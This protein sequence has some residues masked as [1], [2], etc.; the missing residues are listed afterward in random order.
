MKTFS[1]ILTIL[2]L[3]NCIMSCKQSKNPLLEE[4]DTPYNTPPFDKI[5]A[6]H[7]KPA[8]IEAIKIH[9]EEIEKII[10]DK[11]DPTFENCIVRLDNSGEKLYEITLILS[12]LIE[13]NYNDTL[14]QISQEMFP[15][16]S[17]H[18]DEILLNDKLFQKIKFLHDN[19]NDLE[20]NDEQKRTLELYYRDFVRAGALLNDADKEKLKEI[21]QRLSVLTLNFGFNVQ[22]DNNNNILVIDNKD[23]LKGMPESLI[24]TGEKIAKERNMTGKWVYTTDKAVMIPFLQYCPNRELRK[25]LYD[26][27]LMRGDNDNENDNK[28]LIKEILDLRIQK[29]N[30]LGYDTYAD[31][32]LED[33][34]AKNPNN[35]FNLL[36]QI[37]IPSIAKAK[38]ERDEMQKIINNEGDTFKLKYYDWWYY[39]EKIRNQKY[40]LDEENLKP[41]F[42]LNAVRD[43]VFTLSNKLY[44]ISFKK[45]DNISVYHPDVEVY[46]VSKEDGSHLAIL[47]IDYYTRDNKQ[48]GAWATSFRDQYR[49]N[50]KNNTPLVSIVFNFPQPVG[51]NPSLLSMDEVETFFHE[52]GHALH[53]F[54][55]DVTY[56]RLSGYV[57][58]DFV[59]LPS[60]ILEHWA[61]EPQML[62]IYAK[63]YKTN[64]IIPDSLIEKI[65]N[66][67][68]FNQGFA[69]TEFLA[70]SYLDMDYHILKDINNLDVR[71]FEQAS[72]DK[73]GLI[74]EIK[75]RYRS[76]YFNH[77]FSGGY[78][79]GYY[80]Y[81]WSEVLDCDAYYAFVESGD[82]FN[83]E[84]ANK[85]RQNIL[86]PGG[87][88]EA[89][90][91][92]RDFRGKDPDIKYLLEDLGF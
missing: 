2:I 66:S 21:N 67:K 23:D 39:A 68:Y 86:A 1:K 71:A 6:E 59:E 80:S 60:Q 42:S 75:P 57:P 26:M 48:G 61:F 25:K 7:F 30:L 35:V 17:K 28:N 74:P 73:I 20:L 55:S 84:V 45:L 18:S 47:Y 3:I 29:A 40:A 43:A 31:Y 65:K 36:D 82:I 56:K 16:L 15:L 72:M 76:T 24:A 9:N 34:M 51:D 62:K 91:M 50:D 12:N 90:Q 69:K 8:I 64:E 78:A 79:A 4:W 49:K 46:E 88:K 44:G 10:T 41:Y 38:I 54:F 32:V 53:A 85:F 13:A 89:D 19:I 92:Y 33:R 70:A 83:K 77:I 87:K 11:N 52:F 22:K 81:L 58:R 63:H 14:E 5:R 27:Y 37:W